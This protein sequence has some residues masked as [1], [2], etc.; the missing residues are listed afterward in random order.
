MF[1][2]CH[3]CKPP[4]RYPGCQD[5]CPDGKADKAEYNE[6]KAAYEKATGKDTMAVY[7]QR[8]DSITR[9][10]KRKGKKC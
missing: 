8:V 5:H 7:S 6:K 4:K 10:C 9:C 3:H 1:E 2:H